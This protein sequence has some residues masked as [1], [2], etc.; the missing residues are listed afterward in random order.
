MLQ[1]LILSAKQR[2]TAEEQRI[3]NIGQAAPDLAP[4]FSS[5]SETALKGGRV[6]VVLLENIHPKATEILEDAQFE[7]HSYSRALE[8]EELVSV[9]A[10]CHILGIR[11][12]TQLDAEFFKNIGSRD[13]R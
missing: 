6:K 1:E 5:S 8:G 2:H 4:H 12:K 7:V 10:D 3:G 9:A 13:H 11:S